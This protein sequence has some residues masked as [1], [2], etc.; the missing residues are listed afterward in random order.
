MAA[1]K[2]IIL[3]VHIFCGIL[4]LASGILV[5]YLRKGNVLHRKTGR[6]YFYAVTGIFLTAVPLSFLSGSLFLFTISVFSFYNA[7]SGVRYI[8]TRGKAGVLDKIAVIL[9]L[10]TGAVML[11]Y[12]AFLFVKAEYSAGLILMTFG[13][14]CTLIAVVDIR[15]FFGI[16]IKEHFLQSHVSRMTG[17][18]IA[19]VTAFAVIN[20]DSVHPLITWLG[21]GLIG[22]L[23]MVR[24]KRQIRRVYKTA[25]V[26]LFLNAPAIAQPYVEGGKTMHRFAQTTIGAD[27]QWE[28]GAKI[29]DRTGRDISL[30]PQLTPRIVIGGIH[31][32]GHVDF[33]LNI[34]LF[35]VS[36]PKEGIRYTHK[37]DFFNVKLYPWPV[38]DKKARPFAGAG[39]NIQSYRQVTDTQEGAVVSS[40]S[41]PVSVG[42]TLCRKSMLFESGV[43]YAFGGRISYYTDRMTKAEVQQPSFAAWLAV[44]WMLETTLSAESYKE[45]EAE[46]Y[47]A[48]KKQ[49]KLNSYSLGLGLSSVWFG[50][51]SYIRASAPY[52][53][54]L[55]G[56][57]F[58][59]AGLGYYFEG[60]DVHFNLAF[61][62]MS[63]KSSAYGSS[64]SL[65]DNALTLEAYK[66]LFSY[67]GFVPF[68]G[69]ALS[70]DEL[71]AVHEL[72][73]IKKLNI[74]VRKLS[75]LLTFGWDIRPNRIQWVILRTNLRYHPFLKQ[76]AENGTEISFNH[77]EFN[78][79]QLVVYPQRR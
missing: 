34:P 5:I 72:D 48:R 67:N 53:S 66:F 26:L 39:Y 61:R 20:L 65:R 32:W 41:I 30:S 44:K 79:I 62:S 47:E 57:V 54:D 56:A 71:T 52:L 60:P 58:P 16:N 43:S 76:S 42:I 49:G 13:S 64:F 63:A 9:T 18:F 46:I 3:A 2:S 74:H 28:Q 50:R 40:E 25:A 11:A 77:F 1:A 38:K 36:S 12:A 75:P 55:N 8:N 21:P 23:L 33:S 78:F 29:T 45:R 19:V 37:T 59:E 14:V 17:S 6:V 27:M 73:G 24:F 31:F 69:P 51:S 4:S 10:A 70:L 68:I 15:R 7:F 35:H 22:T